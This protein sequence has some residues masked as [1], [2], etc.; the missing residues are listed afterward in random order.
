V[1]I[2]SF[3]PIDPGAALRGSNQPGF[4]DE[5]SKYISFK[6][7]KSETGAT[8]GGVPQTQRL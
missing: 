1:A 4:A 5:E 7:V 2:V 3:V 6:S 8:P